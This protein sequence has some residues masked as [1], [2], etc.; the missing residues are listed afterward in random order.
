MLSRIA[1]YISRNCIASLSAAVGQNSIEVVLV[2]IDLLALSQRRLFTARAEVTRDEQLERQLDLLLRPTRVQIECD[3][4]SRFRNFS[5]ETVNSS[6][7]LIR[8]EIPA[9]LSRCDAATPSCARAPA[10]A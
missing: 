8:F 4:T 9:E 7:Y 1:P 5:P 2:D 6:P 10:R 3:R